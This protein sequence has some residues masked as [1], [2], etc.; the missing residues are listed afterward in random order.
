MGL[1][2]EVVE[3]LTSPE[4]IGIADLEAAAAHVER[5]RVGG[6]GLRLDRVGSSLGRCLH[7]CQGPLQVLVV[8]AA[9][10]GDHYRRLVRAHKAAGAA[11]R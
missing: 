10:F 4:G 5:H 6:A 2:V 7:D 9:H 3:V 1:L 8:I 11:W